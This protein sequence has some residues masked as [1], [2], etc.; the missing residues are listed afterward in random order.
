[1]R[2]KNLLKKILRFILCIASIVLFIGSPLYGCYIT[3]YT[4]FYC[5]IVDVIT[6]LSAIPIGSILIA[7]GIVKIIFCEVPGLLIGMAGIAL[8]LLIT[9]ILDLFDE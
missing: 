2:V 4:M 1:M 9:I 5:G 8:S 3:I 7:K 6:G